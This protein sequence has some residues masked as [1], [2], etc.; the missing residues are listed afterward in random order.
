M[1]KYRLHMYGSVLVKERPVTFTGRFVCINRVF[2]L[3]RRLGEGSSVWIY[4]CM[5]I[6]LVV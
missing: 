1:H 2:D 5:G 3:T 6:C 4:T